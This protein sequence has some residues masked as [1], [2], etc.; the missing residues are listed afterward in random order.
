MLEGSNRA[1]A[2]LHGVGGLLDAQARDDPQQQ[3]LTLLVGQACEQGVDPFSLAD[4]VGEVFGGDRLGKVV[5]S[6]RCHARP[7]GQVAALVDQGVPSDPEHPRPKLSVAA[8]ESLDAAERAYEH[9]VG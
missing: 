7:P 5:V 8:F 9:L 2:P 3:D 6:R 1:W 4:L